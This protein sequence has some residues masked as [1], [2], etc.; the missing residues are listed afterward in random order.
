M[1]Y[2]GL[3]A[4]AVV[5]AMS[6]IIPVPNGRASLPGNTRFAIARYATTLQAIDNDPGSSG[7][8]GT[9]NSWSVRF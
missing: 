1:R 5:S 7:D 2:L 6:A 4:W 9:L 8:R 3:K